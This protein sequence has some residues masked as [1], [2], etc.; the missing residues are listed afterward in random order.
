MPTFPSF[1]VLRTFI[2]RPRGIPSTADWYLP[3]ISLL[4]KIRVPIFRRCLIFKVRSDS[5]VRGSYFEPLPSG[6]N[7]I[8]PHRLVFVNRYFLPEQW[9]FSLPLR[10]TLLETSWYY[11]ILCV[12]LSILLKHFLS[13]FFAP[14][15]ALLYIIRFTPPCQ[16]FFAFLWTF[17]LSYYI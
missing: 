6:R 7:V 14:R 1:C 15:K 4:K 16:L 5:K 9:P 11:I 3:Q 2:L 17:L 8:L 13:N 12:R 10:L